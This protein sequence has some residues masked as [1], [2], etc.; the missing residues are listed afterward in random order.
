MLSPGWVWMGNIGF[1]ALLVWAI[2][3]APWA[4]L[5]SNRY[6]HVF[7]GASAT[8]MVFWAFKAGVSPGLAL[9]HLGATLFTLMFGWQFALIGL[10]AVL[11]G[12]TAQGHGGWS[13]IGINGL[14]DLALPVIISW[15]IYRSVERYLPNNLFIYI[16]LCGFFG[17][18]AAIGISSV[19][20][21]STLLL[22]GAYSPDKLLNEYLPFVPLIMFP[23][24][25]LT[26]AIVTLLVVF[27]PDWIT[28]FDDNRYLKGK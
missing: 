24:A 8:L 1:I 5:L 23:E 21:F 3:T 22:S 25:F 17:A 6:Q 4:R 26:G 28:T 12:V 13:M 16:Y 15:W 10:T 18:A 14:L 19:A 9:H 2:V 11:L 20:I 27:A 7:F